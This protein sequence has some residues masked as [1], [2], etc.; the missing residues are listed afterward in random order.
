MHLLPIVKIILG[1]LPDFFMLVWVVFIEKYDYSN[2]K[3]NISMKRKILLI[4]AALILIPTLLS[5]GFTSQAAGK[6][7]SSGF[8]K[9]K[10]GTHYYYKNG[11]QAKG[12]VTIN[13]HTYIFNS[14]GIMQK[15]G[16][17]TTK[18][19]NTYYLRKNGTA[20]KGKQ[21]IKRK[22]Y[23]FSKIGR[24][25]KGMYKSPYTGKKYYL[26]PKTGVLLTNSWF[27]TKKGNKMYFGSSGAA[28]T[29]K[30]TIGKHTYL[31][32]DK[33][34]MKKGFQKLN[35]HTYYFRKKGGAMA[36]GFLRIKGN[37]Y[38]FNQNGIMQ[39][40][41]QTLN[42]K[43]FYFKENGCM[44]TGFQKINGNT[45]YFTKRGVMAKGF[46]KLNGETYYF[47]DNGTMA[48]GFQKINGKT[49]YYKENGAQAH[50][51]QTIGKDRYYF[52]ADGTLLTG[53]VKIGNCLYV[54]NDKGVIYRTVDGNKKMVALTF[55]DGPSPYTPLVLDTLEKYNTVATFFVVG[56]R[57]STY[58][59]YLKREYALG[60][61]IGTH[62]YDHAWLNR[63]SADEVKEEIKKG[64]DAIIREIGVAPTLMRP[65]GGCVNDTV[66][67]NVGLPM[68]MWSVDTRDWETRSTPTTIT[69]VVDGAY[70]GAIILI[71]DLHQSTAIAS[72]TFI[73]KLIENGYQLVT[74]SEMAELRGVTMEAG[75]S[76]N[77][78]R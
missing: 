47:H 61:E 20:L 26:N 45:Y 32:S 23:I 74:V 29:G 1:S 14:K 48:T 16:W 65:P 54:A 67:E 52:K 28:Y 9:E 63:L 43:T 39:T 31:F 44:L 2:R 71:H 22:T 35:G 15:N 11:K 10:N 78:F 58:S 12:R 62:T 77:S 75:Q 56:N 50:G 76:Y 36:T 34:A 19:G 66:R 13:G 37:M 46:K 41:F 59:S 51:M 18:R 38:Y 64:S 3:E 69:R 53:R 73:P 30:H 40:G 70:D 27:T 5:A 25:R 49:Y 33:G 57:C 72:Q 4:F 7:Q 8:V 17:Y 55:D 24:M 68:I 6:K 60:C 42:N 21:T